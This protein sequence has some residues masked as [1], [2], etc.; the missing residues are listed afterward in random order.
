MA[1][2]PIL[3]WPLQ[4]LALERLCADSVLALAIIE[5]AADGDSDEELRRSLLL[6]EAQFEKE[7]ERI[8]AAFERLSRAFIGHAKLCDQ[9]AFDLNDDARLELVRLAALI[10]PAENR[11]PAEVLEQL[12]R[13][14]FAELIERFDGSLAE[15]FAILDRLPT[16]LR[17]ASEIDDDAGDADDPSE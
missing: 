2:R 14:T 9:A 4:T 7:V 6:S 5:G 1:K 16:I 3:D 11:S 17:A 8:A 15:P 10:R 13:L 12:R